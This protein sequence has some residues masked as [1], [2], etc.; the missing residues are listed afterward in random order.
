MKQ[1]PGLSAS[2][3]FDLLAEAF[4]DLLDELL[5]VRHLLLQQFAHAQVV[6]LVGQPRRQPVVLAEDS[7]DVL[8]EMAVL[9]LA[10]RD[11]HGVGVVLAHELVHRHVDCD[12]RGQAEVVLRVLAL[13]VAV[14]VV[15]AGAVR[16]HDVQHLVL[17]DPQRLFE[18]QWVREVRVHHEGVP[19]LADGDAERRD[20]LRVLAPQRRDHEGVEVANARTAEVGE[21]VF[22]S[23][24]SG[25]GFLVESARRL[26][27]L[28][29]HG[30]LDF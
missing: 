6:V 10:H 12:G 24:L 23:Y 18:G 22:D 30:S 11:H 5:G 13:A 28:V 2:R 1:R 25:H 7:R 16:Q 14:D 19:A 21:G 9:R 27:K 15:P 8:G 3:L 29:P 26:C 4:D 17:E 20:R